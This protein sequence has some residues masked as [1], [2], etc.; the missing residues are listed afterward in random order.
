MGASDD[1]ALVYFLDANV[2]NN[3]SS[4]AWVY[5]VDGA[6]A[7]FRGDARPDFECV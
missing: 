7:E 1:T 3:I 5:F 4:V 6:L 2:R